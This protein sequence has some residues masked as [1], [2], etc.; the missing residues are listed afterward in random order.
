[1]NLFS[2]LRSKLGSEFVKKVKT[3]AYF[4]KNLVATKIIEVFTLKCKDE[5]ITPQSLCLKCPIRTENASNIIERAPKQLV[6][7]RI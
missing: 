6:R 5:G 4:E 7:E 3:V 2:H 1:M